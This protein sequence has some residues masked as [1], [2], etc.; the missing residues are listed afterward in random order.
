M[1]LGMGMVRSTW[2][3]GEPKL[4]VLL[5][6]QKLGAAQVDV[7][8]GKEDEKQNQTAGQ[9]MRLVCRPTEADIQPGEQSFSMVYSDSKQQPYDWLVM[10][11]RGCL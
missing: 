3:E 9:R 6:A 10:K 8:S 1:V 4:E 2:K 7:H 11:K 5:S